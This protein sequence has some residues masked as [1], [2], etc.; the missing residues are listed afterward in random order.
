MGKGW[1][2][3]KKT[4]NNLNN[5]EISELPPES[6]R[7]LATLAQSPTGLLL[8]ANIAVVIRLVASVCM[9]ASLC[10][11]LTCESLNLESLFT[12]LHGMQ[13]RCSDENSV[14]LSV[15]RAHCDKTE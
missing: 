3:T 1:K 10:N 14:R 2:R 12:S 5:N 11:A 8:P 4:R 6:Y 15:K 9:S 13:T 7:D